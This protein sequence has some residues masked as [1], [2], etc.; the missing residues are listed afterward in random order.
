M[1]TSGCLSKR[2]SRTVQIPVAIHKNLDT[3]EVTMT[4]AEIDSETLG[5]FFAELYNR[6]HPEKPLVKKTKET[7]Q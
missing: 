6:Q 7:D 4:C 3:G 5:D 2:G 1:M